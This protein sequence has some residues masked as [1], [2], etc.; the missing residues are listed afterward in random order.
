MQY[1]KEKILTR[2]KKLREKRKISAMKIK[3]Q[4][5]L[6][7]RLAKEKEKYAKLIE[8]AKNKVDIQYELEHKI[9]QIL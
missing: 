4:N 6:E 1:N 2:D 8:N 5:R 7:K 9:I 3:N